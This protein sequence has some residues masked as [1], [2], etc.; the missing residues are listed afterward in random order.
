MAFK[1]LMEA[2]HPAACALAASFL[3]Q[4]ASPEAPAHTPAALTG[5]PDC[6]EVRLGNIQSR[7]LNLKGTRMA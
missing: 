7:M 1:G 2:A 3:E 6:L 4:P 5:Y